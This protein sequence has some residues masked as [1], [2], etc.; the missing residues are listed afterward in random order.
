M[1]S[2]PAGYA[3]EQNVPNPF[4]PETQISYRVPERAEVRLSVYNV[5]GQQVAQLVSATLEPG[6][7][8]VTWDGRDGVGRAVASGVYFYRLETEAIQLVRKMLLLQ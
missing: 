8:R 3:L 2:M 4:N 5:T 7:Y 1:E 6:V